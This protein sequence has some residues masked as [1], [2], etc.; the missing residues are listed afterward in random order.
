[1]EGTMINV[2][3]NANA[4]PKIIVQ[5][6]GFQ[7][8]TLSPPKKICGFNEENN[9]I[10]LILN[11]TAIGINPKMA[12]NAVNNT[13]MMRVLPAAITASLVFIPRALNSSAN[14]ITKIPFFTT[15]PASPTIP[16]PVIKTETSIP[17]KE[18]PNNTPIT[19]KI[20]SVK[21]ITDLLMLL[22]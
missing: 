9:E 8:A 16:S 11:P 1:M 2:I 6:N 18:N 22:N 13:G 17:V 12:A 19:L 3:K 20:I 14:S 5:L 7:K 21:I 4:K 15:M 10:K